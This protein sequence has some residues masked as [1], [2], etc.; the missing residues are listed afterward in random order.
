[1]LLGRTVAERNV[2][3]EP[4]L[5]LS[6]YKKPIKPKKP[7][8]KLSLKNLG[9]LQ[10]WLNCGSLLRPLLGVPLSIPVFAMTTVAQEI[11]WD[12]TEDTMFLIQD[13]IVALLLLLPVPGYSRWAVLFLRP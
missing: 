4:S 3:Y 9:F 13:T 5:C 1:M 12:M 11:C 6:L 8:K 7:K 10:P 2:W